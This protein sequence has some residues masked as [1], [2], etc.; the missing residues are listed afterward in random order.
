MPQI[1]NL[2]Y[3]FSTA[4]KCPAL[5]DLTNGDIVYAS[6]TTA[7]YYFGTTATHS[8]NPGYSLF[9]DERR[10]CGGDGSS[11]TGEWDMIEPTCVCKLYL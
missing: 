8:C 7:P 10:T 4:I 11:I 1:V 6:D 9:G 2:C 3:F 5:V